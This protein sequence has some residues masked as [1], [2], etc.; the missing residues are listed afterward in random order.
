MTVA[1]TV[2]EYDWSSF[3]FMTATMGQWRCEFVV[4]GLL[5]QWL[6]WRRYEWA[7]T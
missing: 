1:A 5:V 2:E 7:L 6:Q 3:A 4:S